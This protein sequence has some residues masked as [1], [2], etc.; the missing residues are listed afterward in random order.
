MIPL[1][2]YDGTFCAYKEHMINIRELQICAR[3][4]NDTLVANMFCH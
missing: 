4:V 1:K 2:H 3:E